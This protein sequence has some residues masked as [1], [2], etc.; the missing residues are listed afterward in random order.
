MCGG[1]GG[2]GVKR[3][4]L[5]HAAICIQSND[6]SR[7]DP[8]QQ[9]DRSNLITSKLI[10]RMNCLSCSHIVGGGGEGGS[11]VCVCACMGEYVCV[12]ACVR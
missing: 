3:N 8:A 9:P 6:T 7:D 10:D 11:Y 2:G 1:G 12:R 5:N 4:S